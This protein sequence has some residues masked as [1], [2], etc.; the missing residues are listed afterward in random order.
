MSIATEKTEMDD[1]LEKDPKQYIIIK[2]AR[3]HNLQNVNVAIPRNQLVVVSGV[4]GSGKSSLTMNTLYAEGQRRYVESLSSYARQFLNRMDKPDVD[5]IKGISPAIAIEQKVTTRTSRSTV[6]S[7]TEIYDY[8]RLL[9]ARIGKTYSPVSGQQVRKHEV[10]DVVNYFLALEEGTRVQVLTPLIKRE[11]IKI[12]K[13]LQLLKQ[14]GF[15]RLFW[16]D[17]VLKIDEVLEN[18]PMLRKLD[19]ATDAELLID[20]LKVDGSEE[21]RSRIAD[22][23]Q[24][25]FFEGKG[26]CTLAVEGGERITFSSLFELDGMRFDEPNPHFFNFNSP[27]GAC[28]KCEGFGTIIGIDDDLVIP[29]KSMSV[30]EGAVAPWRGEK[31][32]IWLEKLTRN[33]IKFDFPIHRSYKYLTQ[34]EKDLLWTGNK[35][36]DGLNDFF[37]YL[38]SNAYKIQYRVLLSRYRGRTSCDECKGS[39]LRKDSNYVKVAGKSISELVLIPVSE[40][41]EFFE[42]LELDAHDTQ[43]ARRIL[44]EINTRLELMYRVGLT[45]LALNRLSSTLSGGETQRINLTRTLGSNLTD[46][47]Y[48]LD[49]PSVGLHPRDTGRLLTVLESLRDLGNTVVVVEHEEEVIR[50]A[51]HLVD[52]GPLAGHLGGHV[53]F[54]G[55]IADAYVSKESL[56]AKYLREEL[57][58]EVPKQRRKALHKIEITGASQH[59]LKDVSATFPLNT[60]TVVTGVSGSGKTTLVKKI[61]YP[62]LSRHLNNM[63][64]K[65]GSFEELLGDIDQLTQVEMIDQNPIGKSSRSNPVTYIKAYD[66]IRELYADQQAS[67]INGFKTKHFS[68]NVDGGRCE[69][70]QGEGETIVE[71]QFLADVH[72]VCETC[73]GSRFKDEVLDVKYDGKHIFDVLEM[74]VEEAIEFFA[75]EKKIANSLQPLAD[76]GLGYIKLGQSSSTLSGGEA[77]RVKLASYLGKG[78][79]TGHVLFVFD[80]PTTGL[81]FHDISKLLKSFNAL[82]EKGHSVVVI[83]HNMEVIKSADWAIDLGPEGGKDGGHLI[84]QGT[85]E[86]LAEVE[87]SY[88]GQYLKDKL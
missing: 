87:N 32:K 59:N 47:L 62:A 83:E 86:A 6:G 72:L 36:F 18:K 68:F 40:V 8:L 46:S 37:K 39:R 43:I 15:A 74:T 77:Q 14:N 63:G 45:Y 55:P 35:Y 30:Y 34:E 5:Y 69:T 65:P 88:T 9:Y 16:K 84:F 61:L 26:R 7:L 81:H 51:D 56:T 66:T 58:V 23:T 44:V 12:D 41:K 13:L 10:T 38:E 52:M 19:K 60:L 54:Q 64:D 25:A 57:T 80:E 70:C 2:G 48:I 50:A 1:I 27:F 78:K 75:D 21:T 20:R 17:E 79:S 33:A 85:P 29:D 3:V 24:I 67:K 53:I 49:E 73:Q 82:I 4:S 22:S 71:M 11:G 31:M 28:K 42:N 76:V